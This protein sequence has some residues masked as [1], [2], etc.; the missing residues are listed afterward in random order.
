M[1][2]SMFEPSPGDGALLTLVPVC[3]WLLSRISRHLF[4]LGKSEKKQP[5]IVRYR[6]YDTRRVANF[7]WPLLHGQYLPIL[8]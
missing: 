1:Y 2:T 4:C 6:S 8:F 5:Y 7:T 3:T